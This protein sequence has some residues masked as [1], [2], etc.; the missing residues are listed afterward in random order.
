MDED[1][2]K[3]LVVYFEMLKENSSTLW[4]TMILI[5]WYLSA[6]ITVLY[7]GAEGNS[8]LI[9]RQGHKHFYSTASCPYKSLFFHISSL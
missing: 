5:Q 3:L 7:S 9:K 4:K 2:L 8:N 1:K 6:C